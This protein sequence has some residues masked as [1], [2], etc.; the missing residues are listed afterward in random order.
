MNDL[1]DLGQDVVGMSRELVHS[2]LVEAL[3]AWCQFH[4]VDATAEDGFLLFRSN[5]DA[6]VTSHVVQPGK[7]TDGRL[8]IELPRAIVNLRRSRFHAA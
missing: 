1:V 8:Q 5:G 2:N 7:M 6:R 4:G 3:V